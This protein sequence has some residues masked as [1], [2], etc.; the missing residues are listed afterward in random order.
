M[1]KLT[2][3]LK[4]GD[5]RILYFVNLKIK[6]PFLDWWM[7]KITHLGG[8]SFTVGTL[9][10][11]ILFLDDFGMDGLIAL[12]TSHLLVQ[13]LKRSFS[14]RRPYLTEEKVH[15]SHHP[16]QDYSFPSGHTT[17]IFILA[18]TISLT[19]KSVV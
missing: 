13:V 16:L 9:L 5:Y 6:S 10:L 8:V 15:L 14:R 11:L 17:A 4:N 3:W 2:I 19:G 18:T 7:S 12:T 1:T